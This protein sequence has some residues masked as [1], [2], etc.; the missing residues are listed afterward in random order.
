M[1]AALLDGNVLIALLDRRH[2]HHKQAHGWFA[3][4]QEE[5]WATCPLTQ[6]A[7]LRILGQPR[8]PNSP[9]RMR[10]ACSTLRAWMPQ[11][12]WRQAS[13]PTPTC[14]RWRFTTA[15]RW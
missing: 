13:S 15:A 1:S 7:V 8:Y 2:G 10:S 4:A 11:G 14:W 3:G 6:N 9:G 5:G 12:C